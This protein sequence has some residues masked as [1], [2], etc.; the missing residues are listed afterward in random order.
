MK[1]NYFVGNIIDDN[2][3]SIVN[4]NYYKYLNDNMIFCHT[5]NKIKRIFHFIKNVFKIN[6]VIISGFSLLNFCILMFSKLIGKKTYYL[7][8]GYVKVEMKYSK[9]SKSKKKFNIKLEYYFLKSSFKVICVSEIFAEFLKKE[10]PEFKNKIYFVNNGI[11]SNSKKRKRSKSGNVI[12]LGGGLTIKNN[13]SICK[14]LE[15][16]SFSQKYIVIGPLGEYGNEIKQF[17]FVEY[18][19]YLPNES[20]L[21]KMKECSLYI[22]NSYFETFSLA[23]AEALNCG[24]DLLLSNNI[25][26]L[27]VINNPTNDDIIYN[28]DDINEISKKIEKKIKAQSSII[29]N[30][31]ECSWEKKSKELLKIIEE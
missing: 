31:K 3:P 13:L 15:K 17:N 16:N 6:K 12:S 26:F 19:E 28:Q 9:I 21:E 8:H 29:I 22:Q 27:S 24:C 1:K 30:S 10:F 23:S 5:N 2:G 4:K 18:H 7:M 11:E 14:A 20:V 25:G